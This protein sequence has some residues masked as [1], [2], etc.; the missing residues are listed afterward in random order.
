MS[1]V[2]DMVS[3]FMVHCAGGCHK[4]QWRDLRG[5][6]PSEVRCSSCDSPKIAIWKD[7]ECLYSHS[8]RV[9]YPMGNTDYG[10]LVKGGK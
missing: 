3:T 9:D 6:K 7:K 4:G 5:K 8:G 1:L 2:V 10:T